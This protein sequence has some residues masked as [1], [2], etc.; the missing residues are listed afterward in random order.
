[1]SPGK[2]SR[3]EPKPKPKNVIFDASAVGVAW[4]L[5]AEVGGRVI[6]TYREGH[7]AAGNS[8]ARYWDVVSSAFLAQRWVVP[9]MYNSYRV[10]R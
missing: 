2:P 4:R 8:S 5:V 9:V 10:N 7:F 3:W 6:S 1:M